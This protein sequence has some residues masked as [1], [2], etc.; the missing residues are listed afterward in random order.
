VE[1]EVADDLHAAVRAAVADLERD[2]KKMLRVAGRSR[3]ERLAALV[4][5]KLLNLGYTNIEITGGLPRTRSP[6]AR[7][8][9]RVDADRDGQRH[10]GHVTL[11]GNEVEDARLRPLHLMFP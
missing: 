7:S 9:V 2:L 11:R 8:R 1:V 4:E 3:A 10:R 5:R 6:G